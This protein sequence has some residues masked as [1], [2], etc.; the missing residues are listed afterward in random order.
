MAD[1]H[2]AAASIAGLISIVSELS[3]ACYKFQHG[4]RHALESFQ[5]V[6]AEFGLL[7]KVLVDLEDVYGQRTHELPSVA[8]VMKEL[9][10]CKKEIEAFGG[11]QSPATK[12]FGLIDRLRWHAKARDQGFC[13]NIA[14]VPRHVQLS[15]S[16]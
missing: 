14:N 7:Q 11:K 1:P 10:D 15:K 13:C 12:V 3:M 16:Q 6:V 8:N 4:A 2:S 9:E 5:L